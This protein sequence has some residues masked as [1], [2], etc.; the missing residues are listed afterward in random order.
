MDS[1][2]SEDE[3]NKSLT[4]M[5]RNSREI[6][7]YRPA[8]SPGFAGRLPVF[9]LFSRPHGKNL[10][11][12]GFFKIQTRSERK[13]EFYFVPMLHRLIAW[14]TLVPCMTQSLGVKFVDFM[15]CFRYMCPSVEQMASA[16]CG[17]DYLV[18]PKIGCPLTFLVISVSADDR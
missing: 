3:G 2:S 1:S 16:Q 15:H 4:F 14:C 5:F 8:N 18:L 11:S 10:K 6:T 7:L 13:G 12:P 9:S 17:H